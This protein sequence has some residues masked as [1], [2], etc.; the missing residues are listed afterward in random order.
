MHFLER[1][2]VLGA[3]GGG[4]GHSVSVYRPGFDS[5]LCHQPVVCPWV[6]HCAS[7]CQGS[8]SCQVGIIRP[9][10]ESHHED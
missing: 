7:L 10:S 5:Q 6:S 2:Y 8:L 4:G 1:Q 9:T 3:G